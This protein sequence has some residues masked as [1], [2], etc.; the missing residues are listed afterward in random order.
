MRNNSR[1]NSPARNKGAA[2]RGE[3][4]D[5]GGGLFGANFPL[6]IDRNKITEEEIN[7]FLKMTSVKSLE[8]IAKETEKLAG[9]ASNGG[10][11]MRGDEKI[12]I[13]EI[14]NFMNGI[15]N[16]SAE[17]VTKKDLRDYLSAFPVKGQAGGAATENKVKKSEVN[18][19]LNGK[20]EMTAT[21]LHELLKETMIEEFDPVQEAFNLLDVDERGFLDVATFKNIFEKL[22]LGTIEPNE[23]KIFLEV[24]DKD[25]NGVIGI[26]DFRKILEYNVD[27]EDDEE[28][29]GGAMN[30]DVYQ[31]DMEG[32]E[33]QEFDEDENSSDDQ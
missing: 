13:T 27:G 11:M 21:E 8:Q 18:F 4:P 5:R 23:E 29:M 6:G 19:L 2:G 33:Q 17:K 28:A 25:N 1:S 7:N 12:T 14:R 31:D 24:A 16:S 15:S 3:S 30:Q 9:E 10:P 22:N 26:E 32:D 20:Q